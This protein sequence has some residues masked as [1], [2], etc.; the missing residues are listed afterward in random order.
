M[1]VWQAHK[2]LADAVGDTADIDSNNL[3]DGVRYTKQERD[4]YL[5]QALIRTFNKLIKPF[6]SAPRKI[7]IEM[8]NRY[9][10]NMIKT[11]LPELVLHQDNYHEFVL[12]MGN[13]LYKPAVIMSMYLTQKQARD[14]WR[15]LPIPFKTSGEVA[16][17]V[18]SRLAQKPDMFFT[19]Y[20]SFDG[21]TGTFRLY[22]FQHE[23]KDIEATTNYSVE[24]EV[25]MLPYP[26]DPSLQSPTDDLLIE[27]AFIDTVMNTA[28]VMCLRDDQEIEHIES[29]EQ[30]IE[31]FI[32]MQSGGGQQG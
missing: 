15:G 21:Q 30:I 31:P 11:G 2:M 29:I 3:Y 23:L 27:E 7:M 5:Y 22:D 13:L 16:E 4:A 17:L 20:K 26:L 24:A 9:F 12:Q 18:N 25:T 8:I 19:Y 1:K 32:P 10:P 6:Q 28:I 14:N